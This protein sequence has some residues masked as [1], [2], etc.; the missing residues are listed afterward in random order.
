M[1][2]TIGLYLLTFIILSILL[3]LFLLLPIPFSKY[4]VLL[5]FLI[6]IYKGKKMGGGP[7][8]F[9]LF[10]TYLF[11]PRRLSTFPENIFQR[12]VLS[13]VRWLHDASFP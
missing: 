9:S 11:F 3:F 6:F 5:Y 4:S 10:V 13:L 12:N 2:A 1:G 8:D 7:L